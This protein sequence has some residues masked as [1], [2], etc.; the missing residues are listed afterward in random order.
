MF[1]IAVFLLFQKK[2][3]NFIKSICFN[4]KIS[5]AHKDDDD[6]DDEKDGKDEEMEHNNEEDVEE[7]PNNVEQ[8]ASKEDLYWKSAKE[9]FVP[10]SSKFIPMNFSEKMDYVSGA[11]ECFH[12]FL[13]LILLSKKKTSFS[14][15]FI[16]FSNKKVEH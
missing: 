15:K 9:V 13:F 3:S 2:K 11:Y 5:A 16:I 8:L 10:S 6:D 4:K 12:M 1:E 7:D 14:P